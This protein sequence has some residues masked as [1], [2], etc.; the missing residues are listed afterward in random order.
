MSLHFLW[1]SL[2]R[3][4]DIPGLTS[5]RLMPTFGRT[6]IRRFVSNMADLKKLAARDYEDALQVCALFSHQSLKLIN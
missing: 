6:T 1:P 4:I 3:V 2:S 5:F